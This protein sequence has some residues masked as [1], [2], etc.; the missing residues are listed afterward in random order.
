MTFPAQVTTSGTFFESPERILA[1]LEKNGFL[2]VDEWE[3]SYFHEEEAF[4]RC[5]RYGASAEWLKLVDGWRDFVLN[6]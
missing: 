1:A 2:S 5:R 4:E 3:S 6:G